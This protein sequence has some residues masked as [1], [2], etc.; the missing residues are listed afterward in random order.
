MN[1]ERWQQVDRLF[2]QA[3][4]RAPQERQAFLASA[5]TNDV[6]LRRQVEALLAA[7]DEADSFIEIPA[8]EVEARHLAAEQ[9]DSSAEGF[10]G[11]VIG[12][13]RIIE[14]L[15][16]GGMGDVYRAQDIRLRRDVALKLLPTF[17]TSNAERLRRFEQEARAASALNHPNIL[18]IYEIGRANS[19]RYIA[20]EFISGVTLRKRMA[21]TP[22]KVYEAVDVATQ[23]ADALTAAH[24]KGIVHRDI[25][26]ENIMICSGMDSGQKEGHV[27]VLDFGVA[28][29]TESASIRTDLPTRPLVS[30]SDG[31]TLG[32][33]PYMSPEQASG[34]RI[35][36]R[37]DIWSLCVVLYEMLS[38][39]APFEGP[40]KSHLIVSILENE[41]RP[42]GESGTLPDSLVR[43]VN[44]GLRKDRHE[45]YQTAQE[46]YYDLRAVKQQLEPQPQ[47]QNI[48]VPRFIDDVKP[49]A[50]TSALD[51]R[52]KRRLVLVIAA[53]L[54]AGVAV[55]LRYVWPRFVS[56]NSPPPFSKFKLTRLTTNGK[57]S[58]AVVSP[59]GKYVVHVVG[60][61]GQKSLWLRHIATGSDKEIVPAN[62]NEILN[63]SFSPDGNNIYFVRSESHDIFL[64]TVPVL[65]GL[66]KK[67]I[68]DID[69][70]VTLSP[71]GDKLAF[72][73]GDPTTATASLIVANA[74]GTDEQK[75]VT[76]DINDFFVPTAGNPAWSPD[77]EKIVI[78]LRGS[79]PSVA[80]HN[81]VEVRVKDRGEKQ[82]TSEAWGVIR[83]ICWLPDGGGLLVTASDPDRRN[84]QVF[85]SS[86]PGGQVEAVTNDLDNYEDISITVDGTSAVTVRSEGVAEIWIAATADLSHASKITSNQ[87]DGVKGIAWT[88][89]GKIVHSSNKSGSKDLWLMNA[90]GTG[91]TQLTS[92]AR[93]NHQ[94]CVSSDGRY[95]AFTSS[96]AGRTNIWRMDSDG[97]NPVQLSF[98]PSGLFPK[99][100]KDGQVIYLSDLEG[101]GAAWRVPISGGEG[102]RLT[103]YHAWIVAGTS[104][105]D[106]RIAIG[107][108]DEKGPTPQRRFAIIPPDG[109][110]P[111]KIFD[112][113]T[114][115]G[116][117]AGSY[118]MQVVSWT[119]DGKGLTYIENRDGVS[120]IWLQPVDGGSKRQLTNFKSD[121][122]FN[123][124]WS[125]DGKKL[126]LSR[127]SQ[128]SDVILIKD[129]S[130]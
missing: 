90:D 73:R 16:S 36:A 103:D 53:F 106:G 104:P 6:G 60:P 124:A 116:T 117:I 113:P 21:G 119:A 34:E 51:L 105:V 88:P 95:I 111:L 4:A 61:T 55:G 98:G 76:H 107:V 65:G 30:T 69:S 87:F 12:H 94:P 46:I 57:A 91:D 22:M 48:V 79:A 67:L 17:F 101:Q 1:D 128:T 62:G 127:G 56:R 26:P 14:L 33:A 130:R 8:V 121:L 66:P 7:H 114:A 74:N 5:C 38:G 68:R 27:K 9:P 120:N 23:V 52:Q 102:K 63:I 109:G 92:N 19:E 15:G 70:A 3:L 13:Y 24:A 20:T 58:S 29:L 125:V 108:L 39:R 64:N 89:D 32:T 93:Q 83:S 11:G 97:N 2:H 118:Y 31:I 47:S 41:P 96:R 42:L 110:A 75:L 112:F 49:R 129:T 78:A 86:Y 35:D 115:F 123:Y 80:Y 59:D 28:K 82:I 85:Y 72:I 45:R 126:A 18:T 122:I 99:C 77:G 100:T 44:K 84:T 37:T 50:T 43:I 81:L 10:V 54:L 25:K 71:G 40:T